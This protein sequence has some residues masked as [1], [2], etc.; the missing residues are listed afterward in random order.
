M[1]KV[2]DPKTSKDFRKGDESSQLLAIENLLSVLNSTELLG[3]A[4]SCS[5]VPVG[6]SSESRLRHEVEHVVNVLS[7]FRQQRQAAV[8]MLQVLQQLVQRAVAL[9]ERGR[10]HMCVIWPALWDPSK[11]VD[12]CATLQSSVRKQLPLLKAH[13]VLVLTKSMCELLQHHAD[14]ITE[15]RWGAFWKRSSK[16]LKKVEQGLA[17][18][19]RQL[20]K[21]DVNDEWKQ[22]SFRQ[23]ERGIANGDPSGSWNQPIEVLLPDRTPLATSDLSASPGTV[24]VKLDGMYIYHQLLEDFSACVVVMCRDFGSRFVSTEGLEGLIVVAQDCAHE[25]FHAHLNSSL[26]SR[27]VDGLH[28]P[29]HVID[30]DGDAVP[31]VCYVGRMAS[32]AKHIEVASGWY[33]KFESHVMESGNKKRRRLSSTAEVVDDEEQQRTTTRMRFANCLYD[34]EKAGLITVRANAKK[35]NIIGRLLYAGMQMGAEGHQS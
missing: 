3:S 16:Q 10:F 33:D 27:C 17:K 25:V 20:H 24:S 15:E 19:S 14:T 4:F 1:K 13:D 34:I 30:D 18:L 2:F 35:V 9:P 29:K 5:N 21:F 26:R 28:H 6:S 23:M 8:G 31:D 22:W 11:R 32:Q 12:F 7:D